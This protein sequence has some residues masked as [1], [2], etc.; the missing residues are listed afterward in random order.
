ML[1][2]ASR[3]V[4]DGNTVLVV[5]PADGPLRL[6]LVEAG[7]PTALH[8]RMA[9][10]T[11]Q[12]VQGRLGAL[13]LVGRVPISVGYLGYLIRQL[14]PD[15]VHSNTAVVLS[16]GVAAKMCNVPHIWHM[17][18]FFDDFPRLWTVYRRFM[19]AFSDL[20]VCV[21][22]AVAAQFSGASLRARV[23]VCHNGFPQ[24]EYEGVT[25]ERVARFREAVG[26]P[27]GPVIGVVGR[28]KC[29]RKGQDVF[30][31][32]AGIVAR[33]HPRVTFAMIG[34][35]YPG[36][37]EHLTRVLAI[38][39]ELGI[40][41][42]IV[43]TGDV[44]DVK[45]AYRAL[46]VSVLSSAG[47]EPFGGVV[48][49]SMAL[50]VPVIGTRIGGTPEQVEDRVTGLLV[51]PND[52]E[53]LAAAMLCLIDDPARAREMGRA[54]RRRFLAEFEFESFYRRLRALYSSVLKPSSR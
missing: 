29:G 37:E 34:S 26:L 40:R 3:L 15:V 19:G 38:A 39:D 42:R 41:D 12:G 28:I 52:V 43:Y 31:R 8:P 53:A 30:V 35:P 10:V 18:E 36:N 16:A 7:V 49:E 50:G 33:L 13:R 32:A 20:I 4:R 51:A 24:G 2:L 14:R 44:E 27:D 25:D 48:I 23:V 46:D 22:S 9:V 5:L 1:R 54:G 45:A 21:S 17:R 11:R 47:P 6:A